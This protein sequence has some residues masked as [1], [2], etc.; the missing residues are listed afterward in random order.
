[1]KLSKPRELKNIFLF[2]FLELYLTREN[3]FPLNRESYTV[4]ENI[5]AT[6]KI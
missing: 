5:S 1:M 3:P 6:I 2:P 4:G